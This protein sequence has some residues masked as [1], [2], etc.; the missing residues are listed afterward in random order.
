MSLPEKKLIIPQW[1]LEDRPRE[2]MLQK[3]LR[4]LSNAEL[5]AILIGTGNQQETAV[6]LSQRILNSVDNN[7]GEL[8]KKSAAELISSFSGIGEAKAITILA[9]L[10]L[11]RRRKGEERES[12]HF[13]R[14][15]QDIHDLF[16]ARMIDLQYEE[17]WIVLLSPSCRILDQVKIGQGGVSATSVDIKLILR[18]AVNRLASR[19]ILCHNHPS[20]N[21][22]PSKADCLLT[23]RIARAG[24]LME[25]RLIDHVI[26]C[27][28]DYY[29]FADEG[30]LP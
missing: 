24:E 8:G 9:A 4:S 14:R 27:G 23:E 18:A 15:S 6:A 29:S 17:F 21:R 26:F 13:I 25:V 11:G 19:L 7:L 1:A 2:K 10:E 5:I 28:E 30:R 12:Q 22:L 16:Y 20:G 3:G